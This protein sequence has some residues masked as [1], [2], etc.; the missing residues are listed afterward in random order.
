MGF[1]GFP[2]P[3]RLSGQSLTLS[4][5]CRYG[6]TPR[7]P[8]RPPELPPLSTDRPV[9][10]LPGLTDGALMERSPPPE[11][12]DGPHERESI[13]CD[14]ASGKRESVPREKDGGATSTRR[15]TLTSRATVVW[16]SLSPRT[17]GVSDGLM[18]LPA[19]VPTVLYGPEP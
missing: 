3:F 11:L 4:V 19:V 8:P 5:R 10:T 6:L 12:T 9:S 18:L 2:M 13:E 14:A 16:R 15:P 1:F 17:R 7:P